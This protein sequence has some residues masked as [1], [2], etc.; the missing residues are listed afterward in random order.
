MSTKT[1]TCDFCHEE[2]PIDDLCTFDGQSLCPDCF[3]S[4]TILCDH[5]G[6]R[7]WEENSVQD[8]HIA[9]CLCCYENY[10]T[11]CSQC[12]RLIQCNDAHYLDDDDE[13]YCSHCAEQHNTRRIQSYY[14]KPEPS[15]LNH[16]YR[17]TGYEW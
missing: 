17:L 7:V 6:D 15:G 11:H 8:E 2:H 12:D 13:P 16:S 4:E 3:E 1:F 5:C 14:Y 9:L 10:Y